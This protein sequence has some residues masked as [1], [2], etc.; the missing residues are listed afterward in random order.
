MKGWLAA[1]LFFIG[2]VLAAAALLFGVAALIRLIGVAPDTERTII[3]WT[4][5]G[6]VFATG[7]IARALLRRFER[8]R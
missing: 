3:G 7:L 1:N 6:S 4:A 2:M 8:K 5:I